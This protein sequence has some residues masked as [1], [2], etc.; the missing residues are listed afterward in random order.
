MIGMIIILIPRTMIPRRMIRRTRLENPPMPTKSPKLT[1]AEVTVDR[2]ELE[3]PGAVGHR[4]PNFIPS[5]AP[6]SALLLS[7]PFATQSDS[8][9]D[10][11]CVMKMN[12]HNL[13]V[14]IARGTPVPQAAAIHGLHRV[15]VYRKLENTAFR[16]LVAKLRSEID[17]KLVDDAVK[18]LT[19]AS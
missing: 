9:P 15:T 6:S 7:R 11:V 2:Q 18:Q 8:C 10:E 3:P 13:A 17:A 4:K 5:R 14:T 19:A 12:D 16:R 1:P